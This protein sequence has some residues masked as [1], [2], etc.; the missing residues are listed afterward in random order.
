MVSAGLPAAGGVCCAGLGAGLSGVGALFG[1]TLGWLSPAL[2]GVALA[3]AAV[4]VWW[5]GSGR[6]WRP[7]HRVVLIAV[8]SYAISALALVPL[9]S[10]L[11][12]ADGAG[13]TVLP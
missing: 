12:G 3:T 9:A 10:G 5:R 2:T 7:W 13:S 8:A 4:L 6:A 1:V 11:L